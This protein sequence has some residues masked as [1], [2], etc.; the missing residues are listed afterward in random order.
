MK[1][2]EKN[3]G[4]HFR[5]KNLLKTAV[6]HSSYANENRGGMA[7]NERLEFLGDAVLQLVTSEKLFK[8]NPDMP[9][10]RMSK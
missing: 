3:I 7:Y 6:T 9:E 5:D 10:G 1:Q 4:Y 2:L 8:E